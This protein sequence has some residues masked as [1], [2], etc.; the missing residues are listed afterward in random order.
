M[1]HSGIHGNVGT[2]NAGTSNVGAADNPRAAEDWISS[3]HVA[4]MIR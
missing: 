1:S 2:D 3:F 4:H